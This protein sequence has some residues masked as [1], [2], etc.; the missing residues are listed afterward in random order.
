[1]ILPMLLLAAQTVPAAPV[2]CGSRGKQTAIAACIAREAVTAGNWAAAAAAFETAAQTS[3]F[4]RDSQGAA[5][6]AA[7]GNAWLTAGEIAKRAPRSTTRLWRG[8]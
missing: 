8:R 5:F 2:P 6:W 4:G 3:A 1:M 7:A